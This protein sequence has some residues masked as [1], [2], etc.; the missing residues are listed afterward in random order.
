[1]EVGY[2]LDPA[3]PRKILADETRLR[4]I[5]LNLAGNAIK[6]T[7]TGGLSISLSPNRQD[8]GS[9][10]LEIQVNDTG[11]GMVPEVHEAIFAE[12]EQVDSGLTRRAGGTG[13]GLAITRRLVGEM[14]GT[15]SLKSKLGEGAQFSVS[16]PLE[17]VDTDTAELV[18]SWPKPAPDARVLAACSSTIEVKAMMRTLTACGVD[19][20]SCAPADAPALLR[21]NK[22]S[23]T[24]FTAI[25]TDQIH[26]LGFLANLRTD[27]DGRP[28]VRVIALINPGDRGKLPRLKAHGVDAYLVRPVRPVSL[29]TQIDTITDGLVSPASEAQSPPQP[30]SPSTADNLEVLL[31][32]DNDVNMLLARKSLEISGCNVH[33]ARDGEEALDTVADRLKD[34]HKPPFDLIF[35]D[36]HMPKMDGFAA[37]TAIRGELENHGL[38]GKSVPIIA[39]TANAFSKSR[40]QCLS[41]GLDDYLPKPFE[42]EALTDILHKWSDKS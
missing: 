42:R 38:D 12:F 17:P 26:S 8:D 32:E 22:K 31:V 6:F 21:R 35:M 28:A 37:T 23:G 15:I 7:E 25:L 36:I 24:P 1:M 41:A 33:Q 4:Q 5:L 30:E 40:E 27:P 14:G 19:T 39:L 34:G 13:L 29:L 11:I 10:R 16:L 2:F 3:L 20:T 18:S 9:Q